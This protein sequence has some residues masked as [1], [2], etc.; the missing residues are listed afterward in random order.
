MPDLIARKRLKKKMLDR[1]ENEGGRIAAD[2]TSADNTTP[3]SEP[4]GEGKQR[5]ASRN[6]STVGAPASPT[7]GAS[8]LGNEAGLKVRRADAPLV[9]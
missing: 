2:P 9:T 3:T 5:S 8:A 7:R 1:W 6:N 4:K